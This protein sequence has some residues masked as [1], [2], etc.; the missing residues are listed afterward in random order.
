MPAHRPP[1]KGEPWKIR[2][3]PSPEQPRDKILNVLRWMRVPGDTPF[4]VDALIL[5]WFVLGLWTGPSHETDASTA[6]QK[7]RDVVGALDD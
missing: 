2:L 7:E 3:R 1:C 6:L 4:E 5:G